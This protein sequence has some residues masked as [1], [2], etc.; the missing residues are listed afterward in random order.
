MKATFLILGLAVLGLP[1]SA[2]GDADWALVPASRE[3]RSLDSFTVP[4]VPTEKVVRYVGS[5]PSSSR[6]SVLL[7]TVSFGI[8]AQAERRSDTPQTA[9]AAQ[10]A[11]PEGAHWPDSDGRITAPPAVLREGPIASGVRNPWE[12]RADGA[13]QRMDTVFVF[14][15]VVAG[16]DGGPVGILNSHIVRPGDSLGI[17]RVAGILAK[18]LVLETG[19][20]YFVVPR[21]ART[22]ISAAKS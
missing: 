18:G 1:F 2:R 7:P 8:S 4:E 15:G 19:G 10:Y 3:S 17:Y 13:S 22:T 21:G 12:V 11:I 9:K 6:N 14:G 20:S 5:A 16:G